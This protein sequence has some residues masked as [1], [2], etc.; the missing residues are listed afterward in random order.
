[1][2]SSSKASKISSNKC[3]FSLL[4]FMTMCFFRHNFFFFFFFCSVNEY[5]F[6]HK[7]PTNECTNIKVM[8]HTCIRREEKKIQKRHTKILMPFFTTDIFIYWKR[9]FFRCCVKV[10]VYQWDFWPKRIWVRVTKANKTNKHTN[11]PTKLLIS[12]PVLV[13]VSSQRWITQAA[14]W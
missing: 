11:Q 1:M 13:C 5:I 10:L 9:F 3:V 6:K 14:L 4:N 2:N 12:Y 8:Q 7:S